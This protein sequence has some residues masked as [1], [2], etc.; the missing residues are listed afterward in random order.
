MRTW[1]GKVNFPN[2]FVL[3]NGFDLKINNLE[4]D[5]LFVKTEDLKSKIRLAKTAN[6]D[7][8]TVTLKEPILTLLPDRVQVT[9]QTEILFTTNVQL[10]NIKTR[11]GV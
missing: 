3:E 10:N 2:K 5:K 8:G 4:L 7:I 6:A 1:S 11:L 9:T